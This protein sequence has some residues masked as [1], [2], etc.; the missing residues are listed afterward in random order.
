MPLPC[1]NGHGSFPEW[2]DRCPECGAHLAGR[3]P[4]VRLAVAPNEPV[5]TMWLDALHR[6]GVR[7]Y[8]NALGPGFGGFGTHAML[9]HTIHVAAPDVERARRVIAAPPRRA[10]RGRPIANPRRKG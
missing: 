3:E 9:E 5:A 7:A 8:A 10:R 1:P 2:A 4:I 6:A